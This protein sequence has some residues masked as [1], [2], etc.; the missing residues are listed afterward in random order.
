MVSAGQ[1]LSERFSRR[2]RRRYSP[3]PTQHFFEGTWH[4]DEMSA[5]YAEDCLVVAFIGVMGHS[6]LIWS[7]GIAD[8]VLPGDEDE[9]T[10]HTLTLN[11]RH[12]ISVF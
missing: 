12:Q 8:S 1:N 7:Q 9:T 10:R 5:V 6:H 4:T 2:V 11:R 3:E